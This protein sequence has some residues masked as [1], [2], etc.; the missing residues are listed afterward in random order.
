MV[1]QPKKLN[2]FQLWMK[3]KYFIAQASA[4]IDKK[5]AFKEKLV[6]VRRNGDYTRSR[7][8]REIKYMDVS[9]RQIIST[10]ASLIPFLEHD[11]ANRAS[12]GLQ[13]A[14]AGCTASVSR[15][16]PL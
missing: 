2:I 1:E 6:A 5:G 14:T 4:V 10:A 11:D 3:K 8:P 15:K 9:P 16:L 13:H 7:K 12:D